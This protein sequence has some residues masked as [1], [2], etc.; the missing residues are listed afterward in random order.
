[1]YIQ[2]NLNS[3]NTNGSFTMANSNSFLSLYEIPPIDQENKHLRKLSYFIMK[4]YV[5]CTLKIQL[6]CRRLIDFPEL[7]IFAS[8][9]GTLINLQCLKVPMLR[10]IFHGL[11][12]VQAIEVR[13]SYVS[14]MENWTKLSQNCHRVRLNKLLCIKVSSGNLI[15]FNF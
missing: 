7:S 3:S 13:L 6:L 1:M 4:L 12:G 10:T 15:F 9:P 11:K 5:V 2:S 14:F 8:R